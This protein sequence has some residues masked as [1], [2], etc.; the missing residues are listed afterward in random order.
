MAAS[1]AMGY[2]G[3]LLP[4][5]YVLV[6]QVALFTLALAQVYYVY[7]IAKRD[8]HS[9]WT[10][11]KRMAQSATLLLVLS[12]YLTF[13]VLLGLFKRRIRWYVTPKG[14]SALAKGALG[15]Y[16]A[17]MA[18]LLLMLVAIGVYLGNWVLAS[19]SAFVLVVLAY[20]LLKIAK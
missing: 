20:V 16:E 3:I 12:P 4:P 9:L 10:V 18:A 6:A 17:L 15:L 8:G 2:A 1:L 5:I 13:Y 11:I 7:K 19:N 14:L